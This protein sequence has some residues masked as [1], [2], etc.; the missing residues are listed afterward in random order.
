MTKTENTTEVTLGDG[1][2][3][4]KRKGTSSLIV[5]K[6]LGKVV[7]DKTESIFLDRLVHD[8][9]EKEMGDFEVSGAVSSILRKHLH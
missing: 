5:A 3:T 6:I 8:S 7:E 4:I 2:V 1:V 9:H